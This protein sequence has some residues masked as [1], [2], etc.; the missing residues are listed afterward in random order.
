MP[1]LCLRVR[2]ANAALLLCVGLLG[3]LP[4][5]GGGGAATATGTD[6]FVIDAPVG[7]VTAT[8][9]P[10]TAPPVPTR[11]ATWVPDAAGLGRTAQFG[12]FPA[13][14]ALFDGTLFVNDA[15]Q[16]EADGAWVLPLEATGPAPTPSARFKPFRLDVRDLVDARGRAGDLT[17]PIGF[18]FYVNDLTIVDEHLGLLLVN[19]GATDSPVALSNLVAF[20]PSTG[21]LRQ[22]VNLANEVRMTAPLVD[23]T[24]TA[25][26][27]NRFVQ[28]QAEALAVTP[29]AGGTRL[30]V[31]MA[32]LLVGAPGFGSD[33][34]RGTVQVFDVEPGQP[35]PVRTRA[36]AGLVTQ[37]LLTQDYNPVALTPFTSD[38][39]LLGGP[40]PRLLITC[41]GISAYD[42]SFRLVPASDASVEVLDAGDASY[43]GR[44]RLGLAGL[45]GT[46]P[47]L[48]TDAVGHHLAYFGSSVTGELYVLRLDGL[49]TRG[50]DPTQL[51][52][53]RG[54]GHGIPVTA[55]SSGGPGGNL[56]G[57]GL[58][59]DGRTLVV[60]GFG[61]LFAGV[62]GQLALLTLPDDVVTGGAFGPNFVPGSTLFAT[63]PGRTLGALW[64][65][66]GAGVRPDVYVLVG[67]TL[68]PATFTGSG[69]ASVGTL[70]TPGLLR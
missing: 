27:G 24:G 13:G 40:V 67:G 18:G 58:S 8:P 55:A 37:T 53:V 29:T 65:R 64:V 11:P 62:P 70:T 39:D 36:A 45:A 15:D 2:P 61:D 41:G 34:Q 68:D 33:R 3:L 32:N 57:L 44:F 49:Y 60:A 51:A 46:P 19:A 54:P 10:T 1:L 63:V 4:A 22:V 48:G 23:S 59:P 6:P 14:L 66:P 7:G 20:D 30:Y 56:T 28:S 42:A 35:L 38:G 17:D 69:P 9:G 26:A 50:V 5:C 43:L 21:L 47:A 12:S 25:A 52:V 31:A 16:I